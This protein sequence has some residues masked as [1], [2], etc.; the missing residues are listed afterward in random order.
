MGADATNALP[1]LSAVAREDADEWMRRDAA[2]ACERIERAVS[3][4]RRINEK[5]KD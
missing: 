5:A 3:E 4:L 1:V 2:A